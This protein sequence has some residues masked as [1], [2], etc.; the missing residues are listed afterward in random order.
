MTNSHRRSTLGTTEHPLLNYDWDFRSSDTRYL[1]HGLH[2][3]PAR[4]IPQI[5]AAILDH[6]TREG[7]LSPGD[8][9]YDP[10]A[11]SG[12]TAVEASL[13]G[14]EIRANDINPF[15]IML[16]KAKTIPVDVEEL[17]E[18][19]RSLVES[20]CQEVPK[21]AEEYRNGEIS[22]VELPDVRDGW[23]PQPQLYQL[24]V[25][26]DKIHQLKSN[27]SS[28]IC[29]LFQVALS[30]TAR[31]VSYQRNTEFKRYRMAE[32]DR[33]QHSPDVL[34]LFE[35]EIEDVRQKICQYNKAMSSPVNV[36]L[37]VADSRTISDSDLFSDRAKADIVI[38]SPPY[39]DHRTTVAYGQFSTDPAIISDYRE[40]NEM[41]EIDRDGLGGSNHDSNRNEGI[42]TE[43]PVLSQTIQKLREK[44][45]RYEDALQ[46]FTDYYSVISEVAEVTKS[47]SPTVWVVANRTMSRV[48]IPTH[49]I[50]RE[51][52]E[53]MGYE[54]EINLP[55]GILYKTLPYANS[56]EGNQGETGESMS[57]E[58]IVI[59]RAP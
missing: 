39:G 8:L 42:T 43:S 54:F 45:G 15:A 41:R 59:L 33:D 30:S 9:V 53:S 44:E 25:I 29:R 16:T 7:E 12:T 40:F 49:K 23:F 47:G 56:P 58:N 50:T 51:L 13:K 35:N 24:A 17:S 57:E 27:H 6:Y 4:M 28:D 5:P 37:R 20:L 22:D 38:T 21:V 14:L 11:G 1:T 52:C 48:P 18:V 10:F 3:Y 19:C 31:E 32:E 2:R 36:D 55:R 46:F 26:R 34:E